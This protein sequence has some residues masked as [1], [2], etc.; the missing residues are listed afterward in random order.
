MCFVPYSAMIWNKIIFRVTDGEVI[1]EV[2]VSDS[3][4]VVG[5]WV[6]ITAVRDR[7][8]KQISLYMNGELIGSSEDETYSLSQDGHL[9]LGTDGTFSSYFNGSM[10][11]VRIYSYA[12]TE[13]EK[14]L[15]EEALE[16]QGLDQEIALLRVK[17][18]ELVNVALTELTC[19]LRRQ[20]PSLDW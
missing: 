8:D 20:I 13:A 16:L 15:M 12:L 11:D 18:A 2:M 17:L 5:D 14:L 6:F 9:Y 19:I 7:E 1:S 3:S 10:D 4:F